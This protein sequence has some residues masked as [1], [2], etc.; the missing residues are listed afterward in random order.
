MSQMHKTF[1]QQQLDA[2]WR[3]D[4]RRR[5]MSHIHEVGFRRLVE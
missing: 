2:A 5:F 3:R 1:S 4:A